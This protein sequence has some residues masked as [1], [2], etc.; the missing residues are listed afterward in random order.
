MGDKKGP[1]RALVFHPDL[2]G[3]SSVDGLNQS[4]RSPG[5]K[6]EEAIG[7]AAAIDLMVV[8]ADVIRTRKIKPAT[9]ISG[10]AVT[11]IHD[12][13]HSLDIEV[14]ILDAM[15]TPVQHRN[16]ERKIEIKVLDR[17]ALILEIFGARARTKEGKLQV[18]L[19]AQSY[20]RSRLVRSWTHL[21]RQ[22]GGAGFMGGPGESQLEIDRRLISDRIK[23]LKRDLD[24][25][26]RTRALH[27]KARRD[28]PYPIV[29]LVGYTNSGKSTIFN[30]LTSAEVLSK[31][32]LFA[33]LDPTLRQLDLPSGRRVLL[34][35][36]VGFISNLPHELVD[37][38][39]ATLEEVEEAD[40]IVHVQDMSQPHAIA[41][42]ADVIS[43]LNTLEIEERASNTLVEVG[44]KLDITEDELREQFVDRVSADLRVS[45]AVYKEPILTSALDGT[46]LTDLAERI[47]A[48]L[49]IE[50]SEYQFRLDVVTGGKAVAWLHEN[51][52]VLEKTTEEQDLLVKTSMTD[53]ECE[54]FQ[55]RFKDIIIGFQSV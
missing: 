35:D 36:T 39:K 14:V 30:R 54:Q 11:M 12:L 48:V 52:T 3:L 10:D 5:T 40:V 2:P 26:R 47:D 33:T 41:E 13:V 20:Q 7:L 55:R 6:L 28:V 51:A 32:M 15:L 8:Q 18:E 22:R 25:V 4:I 34:A 21:E 19:A 17:T 29:S 9:L 27:R 50:Q 45:D 24:E 38:F 31:D 44:N 23:K 42:R 16:L 1:V 53:I 43:V 49:A 37:A 46:G